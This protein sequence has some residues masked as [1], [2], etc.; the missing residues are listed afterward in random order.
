MREIGKKSRIFSQTRTVPE[1]SF[2][3]LIH[4]RHP[5]LLR[6][7]KHSIL[8]NRKKK[9][10]KTSRSLKKLWKKKTRSISSLMSMRAHSVR[11]PR[12]MRT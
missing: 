4:L 10:K 3:I 5:Y 9:R 2:S 11:D 1:I 6:T 7:T 8:F 12:K